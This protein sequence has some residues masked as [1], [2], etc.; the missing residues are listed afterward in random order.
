[1]IFF[2]TYLWFL[3]SVF[4]FSLLPYLLTSDGWQQPFIDHV[5]C[6]SFSHAFLK[7]KNLPHASCFYHLS[8]F[9]WQWYLPSHSS[10]AFT[11]PI[12][13]L[14]GNN[15]KIYLRQ[16]PMHEWADIVWC[17]TPYLFFPCCSVTNYS[18]LGHQLP[19]HFIPSYLILS[20]PFLY[21]PTQDYLIL[22]H[23]VPN[24]SSPKHS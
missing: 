14:W 3:T 17:F 1:M 15:Y 11:L 20:H 9:S 8:K 16:K 6:L 7:T 5:Q 4:I 18:L 13:Y 2:E 23:L 10:Q 21:F 19:G 22:S 24:H 12:N